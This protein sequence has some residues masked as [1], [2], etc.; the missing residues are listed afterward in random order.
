MNGCHGSGT[1]QTTPHWEQPSVLPVAGYAPPALRSML[2]G[3]IRA[4]PIL[5]PAS[6]FGTLRTALFRRTLMFSQVFHHLSSLSPSRAAMAV[7]VWDP[8]AR[9]YS[10]GGLVLAVPVLLL[11]PAIRHPQH[12]PHLLPWAKLGLATSII[13]ITLMFLGS[14]AAV[15]HRLL[16]WSTESS[17]LDTTHT[18]GFPNQL[19]SY[20]QLHCV[21]LSG[22][23]LIWVQKQPGWSSCS[24]R[25]ASYLPVVGRAARGLHST[26]VAGPVPGWMAGLLL[27]D[28]HE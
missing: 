18:A 20:G 27:R 28:N 13:P 11:L 24:Y 7:V 8:V 3:L 25:C 5:V 15:M 4:P 21:P 26:F 12:I 16:P 1:L 6:A 23:L 9:P 2:R 14:G 22:L 19:G 10:P 17:P